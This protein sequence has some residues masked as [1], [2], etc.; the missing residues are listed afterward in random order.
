MHGRIV[1][2]CGRVLMQCRCLDN[3]TVLETRPHPACTE[4]DA[5]RKKLS[6]PPPK[7]GLLPHDPVVPP[8]HT[9]VRVPDYVPPA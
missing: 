8:Q 2:S 9:P 6:D 3:G 7:I 4:R 5:W 1:C